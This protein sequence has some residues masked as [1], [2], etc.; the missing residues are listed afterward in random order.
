MYSNC[1]IYSLYRS[2]LY[3]NSNLFL[4]L[5]YLSFKTQNMT[6]STQYLGKLGMLC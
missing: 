4:Y 3:D 1:G 5:V 2:M 6:V